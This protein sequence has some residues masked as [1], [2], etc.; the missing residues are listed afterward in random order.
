[1]NLV[2]HEIDAASEETSPLRIIKKDKHGNLNNYAVPQEI[3]DKYKKKIKDQGFDSKIK[4]K[5]EE[6]AVLYSIVANYTVNS[7]MSILE[8]EKVFAGDPAWYKTKN[9]KEQRKV[10][11][12]YTSE[13]GKTAKYTVS[14]D[15]QKDSFTDK[16]KRLGSLMSPGQEIRTDFSQEELAAD[17]TLFAKQYVNVDVKDLKYKSLVFDEIE[18][19]FKTQLLEDAIRMEYGNTKNIFADFI[20]ELT[21]TNKKNLEKKKANP[22]ANVRIYS[23]KEVVDAEHA[24]SALHH[25]YS[26]VERLWE[27]LDDDIRIPL[28][29]TL[30]GQ[31][32]PYNRITV[33]DA[34]VIIRPETYRKIRIGLGQWSDEIEDAYNLIEGYKYNEDGVRVKKTKEELEKENAE[35]SWM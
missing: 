33:S 10:E 4:G 23:P 22:N 34:Q 19:Q 26:F 14:L 20:E 9:Y 35:G 24:F 3:I 32:N 11:C 12:E 15:I 2:E 29:K 30:A 18:R 6:T 5:D 8:F 25:D 21:N 7:M 1:M 13:T 27:K 31:I 28:E 16:I 17:P